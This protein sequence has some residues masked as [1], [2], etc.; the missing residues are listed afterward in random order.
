MKEIGGGGCSLW[1]GDSPIHWEGT[2]RSQVCICR[3]L[4]ETEQFKG[5]CWDHAYACCLWIGKYVNSLNQTLHRIQKWQSAGADENFVGPRSAQ[6][7]FTGPCACYF[8]KMC[9]KTPWG[10]LKCGV[11]FLKPAGATEVQ[12]RGIHAA[13]PAL[14]TLDNHLVFPSLLPFVPP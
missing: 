3:A 7:N 14:A 12:G 11:I 2:K 4:R 8:L 9:Q 6:Q 1:D 13:D 5:C 10:L